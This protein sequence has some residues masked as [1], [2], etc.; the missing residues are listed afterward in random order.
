VVA[1]GLGLTSTSVKLDAVR[2]QE[3]DLLSRYEQVKLDI[4]TQALKRRYQNANPPELWLWLVVL[5]VILG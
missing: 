3:K 4:Q 5:V 1:A 2:I